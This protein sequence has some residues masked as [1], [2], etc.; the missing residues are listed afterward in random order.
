[1][2]SPKLGSTGAEQYSC[3]PKKATYFSPRGCKR[4]RARVTGSPE[5]IHMW[6]QN[7]REGL[8][9]LRNQAWRLLTCRCVDERHGDFNNSRVTISS[10]ARV[11]VAAIATYQGSTRFV[12]HGRYSRALNLVLFLGGYR[13]SHDRSQ[14]GCNH[15]LSAVADCKGIRCANC[16]RASC[17]LHLR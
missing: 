11:V 13:N 10:S 17:F 15:L 16:Q 6:S 1:M 7:G 9:R 3:S 14:H 5:V 4:I 8:D 2:E 12:I